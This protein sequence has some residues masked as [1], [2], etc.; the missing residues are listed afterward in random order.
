MVCAAFARKRRN[1][2]AP[3]CPGSPEQLLALI[4][5][6]RLPDSPYDCTVALS[7]GRDSTY[8]LYYTVRVLGLRVLAYTVDHGL[9]PEHTRENIR[10]ATS[11]LKVAHVMEPHTAM[12]RNTRAMLSAWLHRPSAETV[13][14]LCLGCRRAMYVALVDAARRNGT[15]VVINGV[16]ESGV[17]GYL[18]ARFFAPGE[19]GWKA[20]LKIAA[21]FGREFLRNPRYL[22]SP[23]IV[24]TM[25]REYVAVMSDRWRAR[26]TA[27]VKQVSLFDYVRWDEDTVVETI[28]RE[29]DWQASPAVHATWRS[30]C[31]LAMLKNQFYLFTAGFTLQDALI[32][33]LIR[34]G[35]ISRAEGIQRLEH[36][37][38]INPELVDEVLKDIGVPVPKNF[39]KSLIDRSVA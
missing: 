36:E 37:N 22:A 15:P 18:A 31:K 2:K 32:G 30:D 10:K 9:L 13:S 5:K 1:A 11:I 16:G 26:N 23:E 29:L 39:R 34:T 28:Q 33:D 6:H 21:G 27:G 14:L 7:G 35:R 38:V 17:Q 19:A 4:A 8:V 3:R 25:F 24:R 20:H 12:E